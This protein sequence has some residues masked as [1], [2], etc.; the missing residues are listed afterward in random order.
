MRKYYRRAENGRDWV[1]FHGIPVERVIY[2]HDTGAD[3]DDVYGF[4]MTDGQ[5]ADR[6]MVATLQLQHCVN[7]AACGDDDEIERDFWEG[8]DQTSV[9]HDAPDTA[10][11][12]YMEDE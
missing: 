1:E 9:I 12:Y 8:E 5:Y 4:M 11:C 2:T 10:G 6:E 3:P 7:S